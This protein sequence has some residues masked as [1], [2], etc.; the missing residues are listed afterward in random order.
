MLCVAA[1]YKCKIK[2]QSHALL[3]NGFLSVKTWLLNTC[4]ANIYA[5]IYIPKITRF[6]FKQYFQTSET[7][8]EN[9][10]CDILTAEKKNCTGG[11][12]ARKYGVSSF[13]KYTINL[14]KRQSAK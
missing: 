2:S 8:L 6:I 5:V 12:P 13:I 10:N 1:R 9:S 7:Q 3:I 4:G 11:S 14:E